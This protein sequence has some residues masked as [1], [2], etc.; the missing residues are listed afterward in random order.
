M[1]DHDDAA[2]YAGL[3]ARAEFPKTVSQSAPSANPYRG[4]R[5]HGLHRASVTDPTDR[6]SSPGPGQ[7]TAWHLAERRASASG[8]DAPEEQRRAA[9]VVGGAETSTRR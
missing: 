9:Y 6:V 4:R 3:A 1:G 7:T 8:R 2:D 5:A